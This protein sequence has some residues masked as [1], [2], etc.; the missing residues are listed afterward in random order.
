MQ[1]LPCLF[2][3]E[4]IGLRGMI[5]VM[6]KHS[7]WTASALGA[8]AALAAPAGWMMDSGV[9]CCLDMPLIFALAGCLYDILAAAAAACSAG[10]HTVAAAAVVR[11]HGCSA[12]AATLAAPLGTKLWLLL[13]PTPS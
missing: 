2:D 12:G 10:H 8:A 3:A 7:D 5:Q 6:Q 13:L 11:C 1:C 4:R 9:H